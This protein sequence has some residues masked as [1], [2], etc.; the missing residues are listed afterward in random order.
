LTG[1]NSPVLANHFFHSQLKKRIMMMTKKKSEAT[2]RLKYLLVLPLL[3][4]LIFACESVTQNEMPEIDKTTKAK[5]AEDSDNIEFISDTIITFDPATS[6]ESMQIV[7]S[8][9]YK[10]ADV[11]PHYPGCE[12]E[13]GGQE[14]IEKCATQKL[15]QSL[16]SDLRYPKA[17]K[18]VGLEG[19]VV[20]SFVVG[21][22]A[23]EIFD[24][25]IV[26]SLSPECDAEV[27]R[28]INQM[29]PWIPGQV[30]GK[31]VNVRF[32][33]PVKFKLQ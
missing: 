15:M 20:V 11:M 31:N 8:A 14:A 10:K 4:M 13:P 30:D 16:F 1:R 32:N 2:S 18:D 23:G 27:M 12:D 21:G 22:H 17:A 26:K 25:K 7:Q 9:V 28:V 29:P 6:K 19:M 33:L 5:I 3:T 24:K